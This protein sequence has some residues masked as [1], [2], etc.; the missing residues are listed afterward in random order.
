MN[1]PTFINVQIRSES[2]RD[3]HILGASRVGTAGRG[4][5]CHVGSTTFHKFSGNQMH[6]DS[7]NGPP[8]AQD[9]S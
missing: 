8:D 7:S 5:P 6:K 2:Q 3:V 1:Q 4:G 9:S